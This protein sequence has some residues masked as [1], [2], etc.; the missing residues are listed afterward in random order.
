MPN[1]RR[2]VTSKVWFGS[3][4]AG[5]LDHSYNECALAL[6]TKYFMNQI[7]LK[8]SLLIQEMVKTS[9]VPK[10]LCCRYFIY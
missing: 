2:L 7:P 8:S 1:K 6:A 3:E 5:L 10:I 9:A 4:K